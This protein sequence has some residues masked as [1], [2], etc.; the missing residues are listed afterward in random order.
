MRLAGKTGQSVLISIVSSI[1]SCELC[2]TS[3]R[4]GCVIPIAEGG[5]NL[6][7]VRRDS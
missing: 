4:E 7:I 2:P 3:C 5:S 6:L 1:P